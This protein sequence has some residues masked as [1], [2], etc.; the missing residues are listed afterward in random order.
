M[1]HRIQGKKLGRN[2]HQRQALFRS[3]LRS[4]FLHGA[5]T[6]TSAKAAALRPVIR[7]HLRYLYTNSLNARRRFFESINDRLY[8]SRLFTQFNSTFTPAD[9]PNVLRTV[10][11]ARRLGDDSLMVKVSLAKP[12]KLD[13]AP[14]PKD[15]IADKKPVSKSVTK[16]PVKK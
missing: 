14:T 4:F 16:K 9:A 2:T 3:Q 1:R 7:R 13:L 15:A 8:I 12:F 5:I 6:T 11:I 10:K